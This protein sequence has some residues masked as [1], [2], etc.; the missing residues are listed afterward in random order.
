MTIVLISSPP[1]GVPMEA[2]KAV[3]DVMGVHDDPPPGLI[4]HTAV[5][6]DGKPQVIDVWESE[7]AFRKFE[8]DRLIPAIQKVMADMGGPS[9][10]PPEPQSQEVLEAHD[11]VRGR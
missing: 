9:D 8:Q 11:V 5:M 1:D 7:E 10:G 6:R 4:V 3:G 2:V